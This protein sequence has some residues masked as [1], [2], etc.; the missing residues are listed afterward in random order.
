MQDRQRIKTL[1][2]VPWQPEIWPV[3]DALRQR[4]A[5]EAA[6]VLHSLYVYGSVAAGTAVAGR[7]DLDLSLILRR[8]ASVEDHALLEKIRQESA[9][10]TAVVTKIDFDIGCL[11]DV[12]AP[13][14]GMAWRFWLRHHCRCI[15]GVNLAEGIAPFAASRALAL[16]VNGDFAQVLGGYSAALAGQPPGPEA[17]RLIREAARKLLRATN[18]LRHD[19]EE[20]WPASLEDHAVRIARK[21]PTLGG[22]VAYFLEQAQ[23]P[24]AQAALFVARMQAFV[25]WMEQALQSPVEP[26]RGD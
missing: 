3:V 6:G 11:S 4:L 23:R 14:T 19:S 2:A 26:A 16:A 12:E 10:A 13:E 7:S 17:D 21:F 1:G 8:Q 9:A 25:T 5:S 24:N 20:D 15:W 22:E 18:I